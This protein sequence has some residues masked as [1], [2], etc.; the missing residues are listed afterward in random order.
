MGKTTG[1]FFGWLHT[2]AK[3]AVAAKP[4]KSAA[5]PPPAPAH[6]QQFL[7]SMSSQQ[8]TNSAHSIRKDLLRMV[9]RE[10]MTR[11]GIPLAW[12]GADMLR[13]TG[14]GGRDAGIHVR[15]LMHHWDPR[16][17]VHGVAFEQNFYKR[18]VAMD[19][20]ATNWLMGISWQY[21]MDD[22]SSCPMLPHPG[23][24]TAMPSDHTES[25]AAAVAGGDV[26]AGPVT[27]QRSTDEVKADLERLLSVR[28]NAKRPPEDFAATQ[29]IQ[30]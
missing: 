7:N 13:T 9:L 5:V 21:A 2:P 23:S 19:P 10:T 18:V 17:L 29:P 1:G 20:L 14:R 6:S 11:N 24:W 4:A 25:S 3:R 12:I 15:L 26:I 27:I 28:D 30:L 8:A 22:Q 16:L